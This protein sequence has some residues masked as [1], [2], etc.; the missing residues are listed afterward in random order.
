MIDEQVTTL[1]ANHADRGTH[2]AR[3]RQPRA[4]SSGW[5]LVVVSTPF[6]YARTK[7]P[8]CCSQ[9]LL[10]VLLPLPGSDVIWLRCGR[11]GARERQRVAGVQ[12]A[13]MHGSSKIGHGGAED[14]TQTSTASQMV[15]QKNEAAID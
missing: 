4:S 7:V 9:R 15:Q 3:Q 14:G 2:H 13:G 1:I 11:G 10:L 5:Q 8:N 6:V 12:R